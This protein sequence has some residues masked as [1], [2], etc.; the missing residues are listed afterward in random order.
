MVGNVMYPSSRLTSSWPNDTK[1]SA[2]AYGSTTAWK[3]TSASL[4]WI[5]GDGDTGLDPAVPSR[6]PMTAMSG[7]NTFDET[8]DSTGGGAAGGGAAAAAC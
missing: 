2:R 1:K 6:L 5:E 4:S 3:D 7:L 8:G